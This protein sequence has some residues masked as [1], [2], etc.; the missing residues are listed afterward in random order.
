MYR[1]SSWKS[2]SPYR[3]APLEMQEWY[4][5]LQEL[6]DKGLE[7]L[8]NEKLYAKFSKCKF[9]LEEV[10]FL[11]HVV[12]HSIFTW[13]QVTYLHFIANFSKIVKPL[14]SLIERNQKYEWGAE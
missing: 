13:T 11:G 12:D 1:F 6:Q 3:L 7:L 8:R 9:W 14:T 10:Q 4:E 5:Q 2:K